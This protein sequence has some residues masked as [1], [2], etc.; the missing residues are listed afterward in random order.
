MG[1]QILLHWIMLNKRIENIII[2]GISLYLIIKI[3]FNS[4]KI[5]VNC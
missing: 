4:K 3:G 1:K 2:F 5:S